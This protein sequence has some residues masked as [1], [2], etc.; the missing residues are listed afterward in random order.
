MLKDALYNCA[1]LARTRQWSL[2]FYVLR[3]RWHNLDLSFV[4]VHDLGLSEDKSKF[5]SDSGGPDLDIVLRSLPI[6][7]SDE[8][9]DA[10]CG[11]GGA[12]LTLARYPFA[13][14]DGFDISE[15]LVNIAR[16]NVRKAKVSNSS[17]FVA[18]A[19]RFADLD[20]YTYLYMFNPFTALVLKP[21]MDN[22][23]ESI[24]RKPR[25]V[26]LVYRYPV[27]EPVIL[28]VGFN[29]VCEFLHASHPFVIYEGGP[30]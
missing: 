25:K 23:I 4:S 1:R 27:D 17:V 7:H 11:K 14:V 16:E 28:A 21:F 24:R 22:V 6:S 9:L 29:K 3:N 20:R 26:T 2:L 12:L 15:S 10:G 13:R 8:A 18:D 19:S 5:Y 30:R